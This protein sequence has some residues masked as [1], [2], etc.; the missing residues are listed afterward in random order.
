MADKNI[1]T[2]NLRAIMNTPMIGIDPMQNV[3][4]K[5]LHGIADEE[6][7]IIDDILRNHIDHP[8]EGE[9]TREKVKAAGIRGVAYDKEGPKAD[10]EN[11]EQR[12]VFTVTSALLGVVQ[13]DWLIGAGG[14]RRPLTDKERKFFDELDRREDAKHYYG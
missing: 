9:L 1:S 2:I 14:V 3:A 6:K 7:R 12:M 10:F 13:G 5:A 8:I 11:R 4:K